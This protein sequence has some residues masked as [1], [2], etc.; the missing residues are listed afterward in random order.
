MLLFDEIV[1]DAVGSGHRILVFSQF[2]GV[3]D[4]VSQLLDKRGYHILPYREYT[5]AGTC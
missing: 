5:C 4:L 3:L 1:A 2:T